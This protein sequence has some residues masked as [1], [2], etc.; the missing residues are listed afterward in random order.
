MAEKSIIII[1]AG[2]A[3]LSTGC[4]AQ[5]NGYKTKIYEMQTKPGGVC[6]S[7]QRQGYTFD[8]A[9]HNLFGTAAHSVNNHLW[10]ELGALK[11]LQTYSFKEFVQV[12][13][14]DGKVF[15]VH[16]DLDA[17]Q[18]HLD[19][20]SPKDKELTEEFI[21]AVRRFSGYDLFAALT[22]GATAKLK[23]LPLMGSLTKYS[24]ITIKQYSD[25]FSDP[26]LRKAFATIQ[27][28]I[29]EVPTLIPIIFLSTQSR[30]D[31]GWPIG[32]SMALSKNIEKRYLSLGGEISYNSMVSKV[33]V[34]N[35]Q[36]VGVELEDGSKHYA[37][38]VISAADGYS[39]IYQ[40]LQGKYVNPLIDAYYKNYPKTQAFGLEIWYGINRDLT[41]EPHALVLFLDTSLNVEG[42]NH[43]RLDIEIF[44]FDPTLAPPKKSVVKV[45]FESN[46]DYWHQ[47]AEQPEKYRAEKQ[48]IADQIA[49]Q[50]E[51]R[52]P[53]FKTQIEAQDVVTPVSVEHWTSSYRGCQA[54]GAPKEYAK[55]ASKNGVSKT[56]PGLENFYMVGQWAGGTIGLNTVCLLGRNLVKEICRKDNKKFKTT[57]V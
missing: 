56:L 31:G 41:G 40:M 54:W 51:K 48:K 28:D 5:M 1:G 43:N 21:K 53:E 37:N 55:Q 19:E 46:Y 29:P 50:L 32:G 27:Y 13:D 42:Q 36:T 35:N 9:I 3:G 10:Q 26:F 23:M 18:K 45:V 38:T 57:T 34:E 22:G 20:L 12:E 33:L 30:G 14:V 49:Q 4:F 7:W 2:L 15:T 8:Y 6:V 44:S 47:L 17:L 52:F 25:Q 11:G 24:K 39:T 16:T